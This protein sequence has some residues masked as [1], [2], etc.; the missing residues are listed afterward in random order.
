MVD[1][2]FIVLGFFVHTHKTKLIYSVYH[3]NVMVKVD[4]VKTECY[5]VCNKDY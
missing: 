2:A 3:C 5:T 1:M 4:E